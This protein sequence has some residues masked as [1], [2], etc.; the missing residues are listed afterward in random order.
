MLVPESVKY[1]G[2]PV[3][4][5][6]RR[7]W[8]LVEQVA[9]ARGQRHDVD[10]RRNEIGLGEQIETRRAARARIRH[11]IVGEIRRALRVER[12][13]ADRRRRV[14]RH[15]DAAVAGSPGRGDAAL[16]AGRGHDRDALARQALDRLHQR[17][18]EDRFEHRV[19]ERDVDDLDLVGL[20]VARDPLERVDHVAGVARAVVAE[21]A[22][23]DDV[24]VGRDAGI[25]AVPSARRCPRQ[26]RR[27]ACRGR[28]CRPACGR[29]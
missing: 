28:S 23:R 1:S 7:C 20:V 27:R 18:G 10:A 14:A 11:A 6:T 25:Q 4:P 17:V 19:A 3:A 13:D 12:A 29:R 24:D 26:C 15:A 21:H 8:I 5:G 16:V 22:Q 2:L 9:A